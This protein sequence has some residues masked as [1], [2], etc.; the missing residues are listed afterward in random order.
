MA[1]IE[2][3]AAEAAAALG[4]S[5]IAR[6]A[7]PKSSSPVRSMLDKELPL[8]F[9]IS[10]TMSTRAV[11]R[12]GPRPGTASTKRT[13]FISIDPKRNLKYGTGKHIMVE[14][15]PQPSEDPN[16]PL[17]WPLW[18]KNLNFAALLSM[19][20]V[21]G[22]MKTALISVHRVLA[23]DQDVN[24]SSAAALTAVPLM[25]S[26]LSGMASTI[27]A[28]IWGKRP[29]YLGSMAVLFIG[30]AW[31]INTR[32][33]F[34]QNM[35]AR[36]FQGLGWGAFD[37]LVLGS[38]LD[39]FFEHERQSKIVLYNA[40]SLATTW[41]APL[42]GGAA[43]MRPRGFLTQFEIFTPILVVL[44]PL[45]I[46]GAP[47]TT[48][49]RSSFDQSNDNFPTLTRSQS[50]LPTITFSKDAVLDYLRDVKWQPYKAI[51]VDRTLIM[52]APR[53][54]V[55]PSTI[56]LFVITILP[57]VSVWG[58]TSSL[59]LLFSPAPFNLV[60]S[61][62]GA[63]FF[64]PFL[65]GTGAV[66]GLSWVFRRHRISCTIHLLILAV[67]ATFASIG[68]LGFGLYIMGSAQRA[69]QGGGVVVSGLVF[70]RNSISFPVISFLLGLLALG[71]ATLD[72]TIQPVV[73]QSTAFTSA[74]MNVALRNIA[75]MQAGL[76]ALRNLVAGAFVLGLPATVSTA[77]GLR[78]SA[79]GMGVVQIFVT[80]AAAAVYFD[81]GE[82][83]RRA[84]GVV[85]GLV[86]LS[87]LKHRGSFFDA[88]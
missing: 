85:M 82:Y 43:S 51:M 54:A 33:D 7:E 24:Y 4:K 66:V 41:G 63:I 59:S 20:A 47:E 87:G 68:I 46:L 45:V 28:K 57:Y 74:N 84:D 53:A 79:I 32:R 77:E 83:I 15:S 86:D 72:G 23:V 62:I 65:L 2:K 16:D 56:L 60:P 44:M 61:S 76:M 75:D 5:T 80:A 34:G 31:N 81:L 9:G 37:T 8:P 71:S 38:I 50:R 42:I 35:A 21:V 88:D 49:M 40:V 19:V 3:D 17:N 70:A 78:G 26:A 58:L 29:V 67:G 27:L 11:S 6:E 36:I 52:Q 69:G 18:K 13:S 1:E 10:R 12:D 22:A 48:Y 73:Q 64:T 14:L 25:I 39:T 55:A 30:S